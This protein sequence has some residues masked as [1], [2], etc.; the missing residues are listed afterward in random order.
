MYPHWRYVIE[1]SLG[2]IRRLVSASWTAQSERIDERGV[3]YA[4]DV[5]DSVSTIVELENGAFGTI[6]SSWATR[7]RR[8]D[9][10]TLQIDGTNGSAV[11]NLHKCHVQSLGETPK[12]AGFSVA[13]DP[14]IDYRGQWGVVPD[15]TPYT[16]P[17]RVG[18]E[19]F[20]RHVVAG[21]PFAATL[22]AGARDVALAEACRRSMAERCWV[23]LT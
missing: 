6:L 15:L 4:V 17:Y 13:A 23:E 2:P 20:L 21:T 5:D 14:D 1:G 11:A 12:I 18:W 19:N 22:N 10:F 7:V 9:L 16:N 8:D 3:P